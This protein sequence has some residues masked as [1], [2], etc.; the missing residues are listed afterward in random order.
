ME[1]VC[2]WKS[3]FCV[4]NWSQGLERQSLCNKRTQKKELRP[5]MHVPHL[6]LCFE[7]EKVWLWSSK[8][9]QRNTRCSKYRYPK[10]CPVL[11]CFVLC[12]VGFRRKMSINGVKIIKIQ[13]ESPHSISEKE[14]LPKKSVPETVVTPFGFSFTFITFVPFYV[15]PPPKSFL[16]S[17][18]KHSKLYWKQLQNIIWPYSLFHSF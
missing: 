18:E 13:R 4:K 9:V 3:S 2:C 17:K 5:Y 15:Y 7:C 1:R 8:F 14:P 16:S 11:S 12:G 6:I 10:S